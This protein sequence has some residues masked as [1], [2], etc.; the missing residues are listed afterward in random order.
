[1]NLHTLLTLLGVDASAL[2]PDM[3]ST[4]ESVIR[5]VGEVSSSNRKKGAAYRKAK[6]KVTITVDGIPVEV[7]QCDRKGK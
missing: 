1:M 5:T 2:T 6:A 7:E 4:L 3:V